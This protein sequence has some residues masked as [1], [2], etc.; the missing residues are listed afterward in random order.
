MADR[1]QIGMLVEENSV[2]A[3]E[4]LPSLHLP[5]DF[6]QVRRITVV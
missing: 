5:G 4:P 3:T 6:R 1:V 2:F